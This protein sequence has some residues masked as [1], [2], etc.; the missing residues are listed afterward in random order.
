MSKNFTLCNLLANNVIIII[1]FQ[2]IFEIFNFRVTSEEFGKYV[3]ELISYKFV[4]FVGLKC[5]CQCSLSDNFSD[6]VYM[7]MEVNN[8][9]RALPFLNLSLGSTVGA[10]TV[11]YY[12]SH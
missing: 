6:L 5:N 2:A 4:V 1:D 11:M 10:V 3:S 12:L 9:I 7:V 8:I